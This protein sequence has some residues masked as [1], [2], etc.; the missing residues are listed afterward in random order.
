L[1]DEMPIAT[2]FRGIDIHAG[3]PAKRVAVVKA[4]IDKVGRISNLQRLFEIAGDCAFAPETRL[5]AGARCIA[6]LELATERREARPDI[7][8]E[9]VEA[10]IAGL[11]S[12]RWAHP[13][14]Y[15][16]DLDMHPERAAPRDEPLPDEG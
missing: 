8:R 2:T 11:A 15:C 12:I 13:H 5:L 10:R 3:Q 16:S 4:E 1:T 6:G 7:S 14:Y 9:D